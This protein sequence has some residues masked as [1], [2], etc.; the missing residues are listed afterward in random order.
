MTEF[1]FIERKNM[2]IRN[3]ESASDIFVLQETL[4]NE[5]LDIVRMMRDREMKVTDE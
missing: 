3:I 4:H 1:G 5:L 2:L